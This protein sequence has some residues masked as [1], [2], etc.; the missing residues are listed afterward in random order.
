MLRGGGMYSFVAKIGPD[1]A[2]LK[3]NIFNLSSSGRRYQ[4]QHDHQ[5]RQVD[6]HANATG[7]SGRTAP[8]PN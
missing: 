5:D 7:F 6:Q 3:H 4:D 2:L 8:T 1:I